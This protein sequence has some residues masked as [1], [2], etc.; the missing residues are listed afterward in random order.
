MAVTMR[1]LLPTTRLLALRGSGCMAWMPPRKQKE[2]DARMI[3]KPLTFAAAIFLAPA[4]LADETAPVIATELSVTGVEPMPAE[5]KPL[6][7]FFSRKTDEEKAARRAE[8]EAVREER[9]RARSGKAASGAAMQETKRAEVKAAVATAI[10]NRPKGRLWCVPFAR[11]VSGVNIRGNAKTWWS[12]A[13]GLYDRGHEPQVGAVMAF[14][15]SRAMP[16]GHVAVVSKVISDREI[17]VDQA[18][19]ERNRVTQDTLVVDVSAKG[20][21][22]SV[23]V[24][25]SQGTLGRVNPVNGFIYN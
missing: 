17:L 2:P 12:K 5:R 7:G 16:L 13:K 11:S 10:A 1:S 14:A 19:W 6:F 18:N 15:A 25:N 22:S 20:D 8:R 21:W 3:A 23:K 9:K 24:A 4:A